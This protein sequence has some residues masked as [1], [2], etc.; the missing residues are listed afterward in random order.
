MRN[1]RVEIR[2]CDNVFVSEFFE[3]E[4][5]KMWTFKILKVLKVAVFPIDVW[6]KSYIVVITKFLLYHLWFFYLLI[7]IRK[8]FFM[9][10]WI[11]TFLHILPRIYAH[12]IFLTFF[13]R[14]SC[15]FRN[16]NIKIIWEH[17]TSNMCWLGLQMFFLWRQSW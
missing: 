4:V 9:K 7:R 12:Y 16:E 5:C 17:F 1:I 2:V 8:F 10:K 6:S 13:R 11:P 15:I 14:Y 3:V